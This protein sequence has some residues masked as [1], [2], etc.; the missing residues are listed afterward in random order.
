M[1]LDRLSTIVRTLVLALLLALTAG[2]AASES[3]AGTAESLQRLRSPVLQ[4][5]CQVPSPDAD[6]AAAVA[7]LRSI[8]VD[9]SHADPLRAMHPSTGCLGPAASDLQLLRRLGHHLH[10]RLL[11]EQMREFYW[12]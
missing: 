12:H 3:L 2:L 5:I 10:Y 6:L 9:P 4:F 11:P 7:M 8:N 1:T